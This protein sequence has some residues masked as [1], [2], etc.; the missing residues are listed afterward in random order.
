MNGP[1]PSAA[2][3]DPDQDIGKIGTKGTREEEG[4]KENAGKPSGLDLGAREANGEAGGTHTSPGPTAAQVEE[5]KA[6]QARWDEHNKGEKLGGLQVPGTSGDGEAKPGMTRHYSVSQ[7][8]T[9]HLQMLYVDFIHVDEDVLI[10]GAD[11]CCRTTRPRTTS[12]REPPWSSRPTS[13]HLSPVQ[14]ADSLTPQRKRVLARTVPRA[15]LP[16]VHQAI[17]RGPDSVGRLYPTP[18]ATDDPGQAVL[19][20]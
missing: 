18:A 2:A 7:S 1:A 14:L 11:L 3:H 13:E 9:P 10:I 6:T 16:P 5:F 8:M 17:R 12:G 4:G 15:H 19:P 20:L